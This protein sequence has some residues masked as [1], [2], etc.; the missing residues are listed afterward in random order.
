MACFCCGDGHFGGSCGG[1]SDNCSR[2]GGGLVALV[3]VTLVVASA[4]ASVDFWFGS[5]G[6]SVV[7]SVVA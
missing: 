4:I 5:V 7:A 2:F 3:V 1:F 6:D